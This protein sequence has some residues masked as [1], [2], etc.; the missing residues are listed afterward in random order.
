MIINK[1]K[2][3]IVK[4]TKSAKALSI[5]NTTVDFIKC[6]FANENYFQEKQ[7]YE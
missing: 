1:K 7:M 3:W 6:D 2:E 4:W 5:I